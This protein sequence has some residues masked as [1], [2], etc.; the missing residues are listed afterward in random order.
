MPP[1]GTRRTVNRKANTSKKT[2]SQP[3]FKE[4]VK[5]LRKKKSR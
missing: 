1:V 5:E 3:S 2:P 4:V